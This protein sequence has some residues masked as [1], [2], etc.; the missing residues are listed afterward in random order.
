MPARE[1]KNVPLIES[2]TK[3]KKGFKAGEG[4][5]SG[6]NGR[7]TGWC[8][9]VRGERMA[10]KRLKADD[11]TKYSRTF[12]VRLR[13]ISR[14]CAVLTKCKEGQAC[15]NESIGN[16][17][18]PKASRTSSQLRCLARGARQFNIA[19]EQARIPQTRGL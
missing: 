12:M 1:C 13:K 10:R 2:S 15:I 9:V 19:A 4:E 18:N 5:E 3:S 11:R 8:G 16:I 17:Q 6:E 14:S 7:E